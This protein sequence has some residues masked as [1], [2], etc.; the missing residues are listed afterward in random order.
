[1]TLNETIEFML[2]NETDERKIKCLEEIGEFLVGCNPDEKIDGRK[3]FELTEKLVREW[4]ELV[5]V[6]VALSYVASVG[7]KDA[8]VDPKEIAGVDLSEFMKE[9]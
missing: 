7:L 8:D 9:E 1:M 4:P 5:T 3:L 6:L 2:K